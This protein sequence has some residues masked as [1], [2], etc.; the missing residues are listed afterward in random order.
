M[1]SLPLCLNHLLKTIQL[2]TVTLTINFQSVIWD[3]GHILAAA[4]TWP[5]ANILQSILATHLCVSLKQLLQMYAKTPMHTLIASH[6]SG[7]GS[8]TYCSGCISVV[9]NKDIDIHKSDRD[10]KRKLGMAHEKLLLGI[11]LP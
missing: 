4:M 9:Y 8:G 1:A 7:E 5:E 3:V 2:S 11:A 6:C 10:V